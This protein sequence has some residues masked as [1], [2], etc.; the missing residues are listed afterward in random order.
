MMDFE[1]ASSSLFDQI[2][3]GGNVNLDGTLRVGILNGYNGNLGDLLTILSWGGTLTGNFSNFLFPVF[4]N[5]LTFAEIVNASNIPLQVSSAAQTPEPCTM[6]LFGLSA[7]TTA[8]FL[9]R[10]RSQ[11]KA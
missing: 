9:R 3:V 2:Q 10:R 1:I 6:I 7:L 8:A 4:G 5:N 11:N